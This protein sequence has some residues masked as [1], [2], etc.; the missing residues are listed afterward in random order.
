MNTLCLMPEAK[1][2]QIVF[3]S[4]VFRGLVG[5]QRQIESHQAMNLLL[6]QSKRLSLV[7][8]KL[9]MSQ[10]GIVLAPESVLED[11]NLANSTFS[12]PPHEGEACPIR[13]RYFSGIDFGFPTESC[14]ALTQNFSSLESIT[15]DWRKT[16]SDLVEFLCRQGPHLTS[17]KRLAYHEQSDGPQP[18]VSFLTREGKLDHLELSIRDAALSRITDMLYTQISKVTV[19]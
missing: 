16:A 3:K 18:V 11:L 10:S 12:P 8:T 15:L 17:L 6:S 14:K 4:V 19:L 1:R 9:D 7:N 2:E 5:P 13:L